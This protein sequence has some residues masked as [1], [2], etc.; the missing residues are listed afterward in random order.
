MCVFVFIFLPYYTMNRIHSIESFAYWFACII[1]IFFII[2]WIPY[3]SKKQ[4]EA[5]Q[6]NMNEYIYE[7]QT[8]WREEINLCNQY[9]WKQRDS[10]SKYCVFLMNTW[11]IDFERLE[12]P[13]DDLKYTWNPYN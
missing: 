6:R 13:L 8:H 1:T 2:Y 7:F 11:S 4:D 5:W 10:T 9:W 3:I 12:I